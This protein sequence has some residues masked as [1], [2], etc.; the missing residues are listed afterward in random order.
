M[1]TAKASEKY[2]QRAQWTKSFVIIFDIFCNAYVML[3]V[4]NQLDE[5]KRINHIINPKMT[6]GLVE[7]TYLNMTLASFQM[8]DLVCTLSMYTQHNQLVPSGSRL[9]SLSQDVPYV[10]KASRWPVRSHGRPSKPMIDSIESK[11]YLAGVVVNH[12]LIKIIR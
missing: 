2:D 8:C 9:L 12:G 4:Y 6:Q 11:S 7:P 10:Y 3:E 5:L 1:L